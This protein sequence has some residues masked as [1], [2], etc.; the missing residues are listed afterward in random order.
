MALGQGLF[1][2]VGGI[3]LDFLE[4]PLL[5]YIISIWNISK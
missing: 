5:R 3:A 4:Q 2:T 1:Q